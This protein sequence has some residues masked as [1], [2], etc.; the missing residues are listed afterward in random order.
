MNNSI[1]QFYII[2]TIT[3]SLAIIMGD[4]DQMLAILIGM[5][6]R[7]CDV[8]CIAQWSTSQT[9]LEATGCHHW[10]SARIASPRR[11]PWLMI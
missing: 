3:L 6:M 2:L 8:G 5:W 11:P 9:S 7:R 10:L 1:T 4:N